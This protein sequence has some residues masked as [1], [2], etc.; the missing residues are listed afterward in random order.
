MFSVTPSTNDNCIGGTGS[1]CKL[2]IIT[3]VF[4]SATLLSFL[5]RFPH[6]HTVIGG[7][8]S[9]GNNSTAV[10][11]PIWFS[12][13]IEGTLSSEHNHVSLL[14]NLPT[15][16]LE[17]RYFHRSRKNDDCWRNALTEYSQKYEEPTLRNANCLSVLIS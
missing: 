6:V 10:A 11:V 12:S 14:C 7:G 8:F 2:L 4:S 3:N 13:S 1:L 16:L 5:F 9:S 15:D 17:L